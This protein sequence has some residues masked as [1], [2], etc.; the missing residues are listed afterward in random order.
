MEDA[1][2]QVEEIYTNSE[3]LRNEKL[4]GDETEVKMKLQTY[5]NK[6]MNGWMVVEDSKLKIHS[7]YE[8]IK[9]KRR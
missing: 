3:E 7:N 5:F 4:Y 1:F 2:K 8:V 6:L 9:R